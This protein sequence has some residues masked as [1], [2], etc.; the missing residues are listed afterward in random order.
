M[1][2]GPFRFTPAWILL[3]I[4]AAAA[5]PRTFA[6]DGNKSSATAHL[7]KTGIGSFAGHEH[8]VVAQ[9]IQGEVVL[10]LEEL[11]RSSVDLIVDARS[12]KISEQGEP[13]GD[14]SLVTQAMRGPDVLDVA[15]YATIHFR[16]LEVTGK[17]AAPGSF[18]LTIAGELSLHGTVKR[19]T[20]P[21]RL[22]LR[23]ETL[24]ATGKMV[25]KQ[26]DF[27]IEP[28]SAAGGLVR[29]EDEVALSFRIEARPAKP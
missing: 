25:V 18:D 2:T 10:D 19:F 23:G 1:R 16:S 3:W 4:P 26:T 9:T 20:V 27:G 5:A 21:V 12:L 17:L 29:V 15:R 14:A 13:Q 22:E 7:G 28:S 6:I 11:S 8:N 24:I